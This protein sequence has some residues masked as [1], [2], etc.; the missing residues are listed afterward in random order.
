MR[1]LLSGVSILALT[2]AS[3]CLGVIGC[4]SD[5][6]SST[7]NPSTG[8]SDG[9]SGELGLSLQ[10]GGGLT[11]N[12]ASYTII[13]PNSFSKTGSID[14]S[15]ATS[16]SAIIGGLPAGTGYSI[17]VSATA[18]DGTTNCGGSASFDVIAR[19][20]TTVTLSLDCHTAP[21]TGS[22]AINGALNVCPVIDELSASPTQVNV[23]SSIALI[24]GA[25]DSDSAPSALTYQWTATSGTFSDATAKNPSFT[26]TAP[27]TSTIT[28]S[29]SDGDTSAGCGDTLTATVTCSLAAGGVVSTAAFVAGSP[30]DPNIGPAYYAGAKVCVDTNSNGSCDNGELS[31]V[32]DASGHFSLQLNAAAALIADI[33]SDATNT[34]NGLKNPSRNVY[35]AP[36]AQV[37]EQAGNIV[38]SPLSSEI[39]RQSEANGTDF[40]TERLN[41]ATRIGVPS[42]Q[43]LS[44]PSTLSGGNKTAVLNESHQLNNRFR[45]A[46]TKLDRHDLYP[47]ALAVPG[48]NPELTGLAGVSPG[49]ATTLD[50]R[51]P[52][53][54]AQAEQAAFAVEGIPRYDAI[55]IVMLEN[56][57]TQAMLGSAFAPRSTPTCKRATRP[58]ATTRPATRASRTTPRSAA[59]TTSASPTTRSGTATRPAP[60]PRRTCPCRTRPNRAWRTR[61]SRR[62]APSRR[63]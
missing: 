42:T 52:I 61:P 8:S 53:T 63:A 55:F 5:G 45:Y 24:G 16:F 33:G 13:G 51:A 22:V 14:L 10:V 6:S 54:F 28:L 12:S 11:I 30:T 37:T 43:V 26:C 39:V 7:P 31:T 57:S 47:D 23:G 18:T 50:T 15:A 60:T 2:G 35:R 21:K 48:G 27:G 32:T 3:A 59:P 1:R 36:L 25:H 46:I 20:T 29:V 40:A 41:L 62:P 56:K 4:S 38:L 58:P 34:A 19:T 17:S 49:T 44:D 9:K